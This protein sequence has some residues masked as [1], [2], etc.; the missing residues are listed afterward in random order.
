MNPDILTALECGE[1][2]LAEPCFE[3]SMGLTDNCGVEGSAN[4]SSLASLPSSTLMSRLSKVDWFKGY[5]DIC[6]NTDSL[7]LHNYLSL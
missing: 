6:I 3:L 5:N 7:H 4:F 2:K 1:K